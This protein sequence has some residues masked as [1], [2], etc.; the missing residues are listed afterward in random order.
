MEGCLC[1]KSFLEWENTKKMVKNGM[2]ID[3][4]KWQNLLNP[5]AKEV[6]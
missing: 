2:K 5:T 3:P 4:L 6:V 1:D